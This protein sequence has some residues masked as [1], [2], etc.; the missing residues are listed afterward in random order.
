MKTYLNTTTLCLLFIP[1]FSVLGT[2]VKYT[3]QIDA[4]H[5]ILF[6]VNMF[7]FFNYAATN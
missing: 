7:F 3:T 1:L 6:L 5:L 4:R 2:P